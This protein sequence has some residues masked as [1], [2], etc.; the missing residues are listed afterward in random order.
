VLAFGP[1]ARALLARWNAFRE[2]SP[3]KMCIGPEAGTHR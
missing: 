1:I 3:Q 2:M